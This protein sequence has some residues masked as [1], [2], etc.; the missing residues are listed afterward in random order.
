M[1]PAA[2][3]DF[4]G[5]CCPKCKARPETYSIDFWWK[6][7]RIRVHRDKD[8][9]IFTSYEAAN[10]FLTV[11]RSKVDEKTF[12]PKDYIQVEVKKLEFAPS[13]IC[14]PHQEI[15]QSRFA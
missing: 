10:R 11:M 4:Q 15:D 9:N 7:D 8:G 13:A 6:G 5:G 14:S 1:L 3:G 2:S 12:S